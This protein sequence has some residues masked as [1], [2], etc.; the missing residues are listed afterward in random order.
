MLVPFKSSSYKRSKNY[1][2]FNSKNKEIDSNI[3]YEIIT[4][5]S[6]LQ[7]NYKGNIDYLTNQLNDILMQY[8]KYYNYIVN[9]FISNKLRYFQDGTYDYSQFPPDIRSNS[10]LERYNKIVKIELGEKRTCNWVIF[11]QFINKELLRINELL[12]KNSRRRKSFQKLS[13]FNIISK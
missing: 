6:L 8:P 11:L 13:L 3:T 9:Y 2:L 4:Q 12:S 7:L 1:G 5:L 10:I